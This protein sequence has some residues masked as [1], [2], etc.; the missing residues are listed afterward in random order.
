MAPHENHARELRL[1]TPY[2]VIAGVGGLALLVAGG[3]QLAGPQPK[4]GELTMTLIA[5]NKRA[6]LEIGGAIVNGIGLVALGLTLSFLAQAA[7]A[8]RKELTPAPRWTALA[9]SWIGAVAGIASAVILTIK[10]HQFVAAGSPETYVQANALV[11]TA[12]LTGLQYVDLVGVLLLAMAF[13]LVSLN[14]M[15]VGL[16]TRFLGYLGMAAGAA[17]LLLFGSPPALLVEIF[18]LIAIAYML[19]GRWTAGEPEAWAR[20]EAVPWPSAADVREQ[21]QRAAG[22]RGNGRAKP[23]ARPAP[24]PRPSESEPVASS[25]RTRSST[26]KRKRKRRK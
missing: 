14:A 10:A 4:V 20:G 24:K 22:G 3:M 11:S 25:A 21:R 26:P 8:R 2:A 16:L 13:V 12:A 19:S 7:Q 23:A 1:R 5:T 18:W 6:G 9:G 15:R 17:S